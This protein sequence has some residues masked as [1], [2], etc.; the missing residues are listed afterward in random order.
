MKRRRAF[1]TQPHTRADIMSINACHYSMKFI[2]YKVIVGYIDVIDYSV[3]LLSV[4]FSLIIIVLSEV[5]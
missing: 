2:I 1:R 3:L 5:V 4:G